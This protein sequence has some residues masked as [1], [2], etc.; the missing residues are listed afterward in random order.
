MNNECVVSDCDKKKHKLEMF[1]HA[2]TMMSPFRSCAGSS[3]M[4]T[5]S[6]WPGPMWLK[7]AQEVSEPESTDY[8]VNKK[9][10]K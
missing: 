2:P 6:L 5:R 1:S 10:H 3:V 9:K 8:F 4:H 7:A